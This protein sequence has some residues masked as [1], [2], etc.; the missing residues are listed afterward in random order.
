MDD[1]LIDTCKKAGYDIYED[2]ISIPKDTPDNEIIRE[3][4]K[5]GYIIQYKLI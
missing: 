5:L 2:Y 3:I 1:L 4:R